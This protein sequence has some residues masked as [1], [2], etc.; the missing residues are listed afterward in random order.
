MGD[1]L[2]TG[3][4]GDAG[5]ASAQGATGDQAAA[6]NP[7][8][9]TRLSAEAARR[10]IEN[11]ELKAQLAALTA[12]FD[13]VSIAQSAPA[14][15]G[16]PAAGDD[17]LKS[18]LSEMR[19]KLQEAAQ[20]IEKIKGETAEQ[21]QRA[22]KKMLRANLTRTLTEAKVLDVESAVV[23]LASRGARLRDDDRIVIDLKSDAGDEE[24]VLLTSEALRK[25]AI[26]K[27]HFFPPNGVGGSGSAAPRGNAVGVDLER[28]QTD[29]KYFQ[30]NEKAILEHLRAQRQSR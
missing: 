27:D 17:E 19:A 26:L 30:E 21:T 14:Q 28:A 2:T 1:E 25:T 12:K 7:A 29:P 16:K 6:I 3:Q 24:T 8:M 10:R 18:Q 20:Q 11:N 5:A 23:L 13:A 15:S 22:M 4:M 9:E